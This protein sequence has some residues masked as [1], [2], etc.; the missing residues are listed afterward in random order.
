MVKWTSNLP[1]DIREERQKKREKEGTDIFLYCEKCDD[2]ELHK[3]KIKLRKK[4]CKKCDTELIHRHDLVYTQRDDSSKR[5]KW[6]KYAHEGMDKDQAHKFYE[7]SIEGSKRRIEGTGG[8][9]HYKAMEPDMDYMVKNGFAK[10]VTGDEAKNLKSARKDAVVK[11]VG[12]RKNFNP[13]RS[14]KSQSSK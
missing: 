4:F 14:N 13:N 2:F 5:R 7:T 9:T 11:T 3:V 12:N 6:A 8:A 1:D 10:L